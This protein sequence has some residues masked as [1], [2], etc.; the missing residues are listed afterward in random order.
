MTPTFDK[1]QQE[2][3]NKTWPTSS[4]TNEPI[5]HLITVEWIDR[6]KVT[7]KKYKNSLRNNQ[8]KKMNERKKN[9]FIPY[10]RCICMFL[11]VVLY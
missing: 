11:V 7:R 9:H 10:I 6:K 1:Q 4:S 5:I 3:E 8:L 2:Y